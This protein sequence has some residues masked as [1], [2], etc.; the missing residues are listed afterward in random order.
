MAYGPGL[1]DRVRAL[2]PEGGTA[3]TDLFVREAAET[4]L[5]LGV[6]PERISVVADGPA[7]P[8]GVRETGAL[9]AGPGARER[10]VDAIRSGETRPRPR[11]APTTAVP[12]RPGT[13]G[14]WA[15]S[16]VVESG[17]RRSGS[18]Q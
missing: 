6:A 8:P 18:A 4:A 13:A 16:G 2:P 1:A 3:A 11:A 14:A 17:L 7:P 12:P 5:A 15:S 10:I 9:D